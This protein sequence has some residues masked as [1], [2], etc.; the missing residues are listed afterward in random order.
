M[1][2]AI[3]TYVSRGADPSVA[4][5]RVFI[6]PHAGAGASSGGPV[7]SHTPADWTVAT[8][9]LP[10]RESRVRERVDDIR[11]LAADVAR[12]AADLPGRAP[13][14]VVGCCSGAV[15]ATEAVI[16]LRREDPAMVA[17]LAVVSQWTPDAAGIH[18]RRLL[19]DAKD[20]AETLDVLND[21]GSIPSYLADDPALLSAV[22][23]AIL[24][25]WQAVEHHVVA[26]DPPLSCPI[27][28]I[29]GRDDPLCTPERVSG[30]SAY[31]RS[32][33][34]DRIPGRHLLLVEN[35]VGIASSIQRNVGLFLPSRGEANVG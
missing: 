18:G 20:L 2:R 24:A 29:S 6:V 34:F 7:A 3:R 15:I 12:S 9:R 33:T 32:V 13:L 5:L 8:A 26:A 19:R 30:W 10:G 28:V 17:G 14:L 1:H 23:P 16:A 21:Y 35:P 4:A 22:L 31:T 11:G 25:D 27:L